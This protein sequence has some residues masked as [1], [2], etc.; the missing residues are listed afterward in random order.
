MLAKEFLQRR[1]GKESVGEGVR[2]PNSGKRQCKGV[3]VKVDVVDA[4]NHRLHS[5][6][7][8]L[9]FSSLR[10][11]PDAASAPGVLVLVALLAAYSCY[12]FWSIQKFY[13]KRDFFASFV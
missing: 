6:S 11:L 13:G 2:T 4:C 9:L 5:F 8:F 10:A 1:V 12:S 7:F 3:G